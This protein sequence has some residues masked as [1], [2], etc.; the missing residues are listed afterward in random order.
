MP[1]NNKCGD[2]TT[3][4]KSIHT[5]I[6]ADDDDVNGGS[7]SRSV[8]DIS[9]SGSDGICSRRILAVE[10]HCKKQRGLFMKVTIEY[11]SHVYHNVDCGLDV[12]VA[13]VAVKIK[14]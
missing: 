14:N 12:D 7:G 1:C 9:G 11:G 13:F 3:C 6:G 5:N 8:G 2:S 4:D 10:S